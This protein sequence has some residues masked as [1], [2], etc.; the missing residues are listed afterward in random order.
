MGAAFAFLGILVLSLI[1]ALL[2]ALQLADHFRAG[3]EFAVVTAVLAAFAAGSIAVLGIVSAGAKGVRS[4]NRV[5][6]GLAVLALI[7]AALPGGAEWIAGRSSDPF[8]I[9]EKAV[10]IAI[11]LVVPALLAI[12][13]QWGLVRHRWLRIR[14]GEDLSRWPWVTTIVAGLAILNPIG[15]E[16]IASAIRQSPTDWLRQFTLTV[17][18]SGLAAIGLMGL[19]EYAVRG[20]M[21]RRR[22]ADSRPPLPEMAG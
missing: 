9:G 18:L 19:I 11:Q 13:V 16:F 20:W 15:L 1:V 4:L 10:Q 12:L 3:D 17:T 6:T 5:A 14:S 22:L 7:L 2:A 21:L 8:S